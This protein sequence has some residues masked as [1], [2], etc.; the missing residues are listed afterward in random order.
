VQQ[1][2]I[3]S[4]DYFCRQYICI[5]KKLTSK[6]I[7]NTFRNL[8][9]R[10]THRRKTLLCNVTGII[11]QHSSGSERQNIKRKGRQTD[12]KSSPWYVHFRHGVTKKKRTKD[13]QLCVQFL[14]GRYVHVITCVLSPVCMPLDLL[15]LTS[16]I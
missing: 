7:N 2:S 3:F 8:P 13:L 11:Q 16:A 14:G 6:I 1:S 9:C 4:V 15:Q 12:R 10:N 5:C